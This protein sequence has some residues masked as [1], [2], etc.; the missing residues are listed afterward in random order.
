[1]FKYIIVL[2][3]LFF[4]N[5][6]SQSVDT[7]YRKVSLDGFLNLKWGASKSE[8]KKEL[9][10]KA[11]FDGENAN[12][13]LVFIDGL[14]GLNKVE[15]WV[16]LFHDKKLAG[17]IITF[18]EITWD[19][20]DKKIQD[21]KDNLDE[22]YGSATTWDDDFSDNQISTKWIFFDISLKKSLAGILLIVNKLP[23]YQP[24]LVLTYYNTKLFDAKLNKSINEY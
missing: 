14:L 6:F 12:K 11:I 16:C 1:M 13:D 20:L 8:V 23:D 17:I 4:L 18:D 15:R 5:S 19:N 22:K 3:F 7:L 24:E 9:L 2:F 10:K 21:I